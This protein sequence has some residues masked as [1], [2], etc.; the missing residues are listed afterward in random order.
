MS[1]SSLSENDFEKRLAKRLTDKPLPGPDAQYAMSHVLRQ[2]EAAVPEDARVA[3]V[4]CA[5]YRKDDEWY[6]PLIKRA[7]KNPNDKHGGQIGL[8][9]GKQEDVDVSLIAT[10]LRETEE[11]IGVPTSAIQVLGGLTSLYIPVSNFQVYP[12]VGVIDSLPVFVEQVEE[13]EEVVEV[14]LRALL[15]PAAR[16]LTDLRVRSTIVLKEVPYFN[17]SDRVIW[18]ATAM[19][20]GEL[21]EVLHSVG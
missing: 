2:R 5:F 17:V 3:C 11:E 12:F 10:A 16:Q 7:S 6:L 19:I 13:V 18:G 8:P 1:I 15:D 4:M 20:L 14:P 9:G 21:T